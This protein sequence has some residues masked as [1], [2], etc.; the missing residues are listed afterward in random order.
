MNVRKT[1][2]H[3]KSGILCAG[4]LGIMIG[5]TSS[6]TFGYLSYDASGNYR[7]VKLHTSGTADTKYLEVFLTQGGDTDILHSSTVSSNFGNRAPGYQIN[8]DGYV[9][10]YHG[11]GKGIIHYGATPYSAVE[12]SDYDMIK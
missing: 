9:T 1:I 8:T 10:D 12:W 6:A 5:F 2:N 7:N 4:F 11:F 3:V